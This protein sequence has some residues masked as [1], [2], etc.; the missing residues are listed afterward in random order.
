MRFISSLIFG[1]AIIY[2]LAIF[3]VLAA[4]SEDS[5]SQVI[6]F[7]L[8][9]FTI[10]FVIRLLLRAGGN[11]SDT[12]NLKA[13]STAENA[14]LVIQ[15]QNGS[16][17]TIKIV[18]PEIKYRRAQV[19]YGLLL[20]VQTFYFFVCILYF[21]PDRMTE[22]ILFIP[23]YILCIALAGFS[24]LHHR[25]AVQG[26]QGEKSERF[27]ATYNFVVA[28]LAGIVLIWIPA[29]MS[30][31][32]AVRQQ[33]KAEQTELDRQTEQNEREAAKAQEIADREAEVA[34][35]EK[36]IQDELDASTESESWTQ[37]TLN[38]DPKIRFEYPSDWGNPTVEK[39]T[40][41][42]NNPKAIW[43]RVDFSNPKTPYFYVYKENIRDDGRLYGESMV[44]YG[45][46]DIAD[47]DFS[48]RPF[49]DRREFPDLCYVVEGEY[50]NYYE[51]RAGYLA[52]DLKRLLAS[53]TII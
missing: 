2:A 50:S 11:R 41:T 52:K 51:C 10:I 32:E 1:I 15:I 39:A 42:A 34:A 18:S 21:I 8:I 27:F 23:A 48:V 31:P 29:T 5:A 45:Y 22:V 20:G 30:A 25:T 38:S 19:T 28:V 47:S 3:T 40:G 37:Y 44:H 17:Q 14:Q 6:V 12:H 9:V 26:V 35:E 24:L 13:A 53:F 49:I 36:E 4:F 46:V 7:G 16:T 43:Y 33:E